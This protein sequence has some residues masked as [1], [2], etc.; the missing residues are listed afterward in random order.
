MTKM[1]SNVTSGAIPV[2]A[3]SAKSQRIGK[4]FAGSTCLCIG[5]ENGL[6]IIL[7]KVRRG[8][9]EVSKVGFADAAGVREY[10]M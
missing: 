10:A 4:L 9:P 6:A 8:I 7:Y 5:E 1:Y 3:D 2:Y